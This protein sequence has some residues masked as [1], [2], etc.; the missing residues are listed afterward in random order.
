[1]LPYVLI[2]VVLAG[3]GL[4]LWWPHYRLK[5]ALA[6]PFPQDWRRFLQRNLPSYKRLPE[7]LRFELQRLIKQ[8]L[9][10][11]EFVGCAGLEISD[12]IRLTIAG[13]ACL[14]LLNR[15]STVYQKLR[16][17]YV[18]PSG[19]I[20]PHKEIDDNG[21]VREVRHGRSGESWSN[22]KVILSWDDVER[23]V[24]DITDGDNVV[25]HEFAHQ[26]D[27][28]SGIT[29]GAPLLSRRSGYQRWAEVL[30]EEYRDLVD[31][32]RFGRE[33]LLDYYGATNPAEFFAVATEVFYE[34]PGKMAEQHPELFQQ[35]RQYYAVDPRE[36][37]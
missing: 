19:F 8:F 35:L 24:R 21:L 15:P 34:Q 17:I 37:L 36:W 31:D 3:V 20:A 10:E 28:E 1:M 9:H 12:E 26:L 14:L 2:L 25:L 22:G 30:S 4:Y 16:Y 32:A 5:Q 33:S 23:G 6:R 7:H 29:N 11:K 13:E 27:Q 18:Y